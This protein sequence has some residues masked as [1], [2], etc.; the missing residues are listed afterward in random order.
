MRRKSE[1]L[2]DSEVGERA[3]D[4]FGDIVDSERLM[5][6][7]YAGRINADTLISRLDFL[8]IRAEDRAVDE[9]C[10][11][12]V[13]TDQDDRDEHETNPGAA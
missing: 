1:D 11:E 3:E 6:H 7:Y 10:D 12:D 2:H 9:L 13:E 4:I 5:S 8:R